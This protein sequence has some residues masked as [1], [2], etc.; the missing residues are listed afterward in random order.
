[1]WVP[2]STWGPAWVSWR[3]TDSYCGWAPLPPAARYESYGFYYQS[4]RVGIGFDFGLH[5]DNYTFIPTSRFC[6]RTPYRHYVSGSHSRNIYNNSTVINNYYVN[7]NTIIN[8]GIGRDTVAKATRSEVTKVAIR[9]LPDIAV[10][11]GARK[12]VAD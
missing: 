9:D 3:Y 5:H 7:N 1:M 8:E 6:D 11:P 12:K 2:G 10:V 4:S